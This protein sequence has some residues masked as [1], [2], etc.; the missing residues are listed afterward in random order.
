MFIVKKAFRRAKAVPRLAILAQFRKIRSKIKGRHKRREAPAENRPPVVPSQ[1]AEVFDD[2]SETSL[3]DECVICFRAIKDE[4]LKLKCSHEFHESCL[5][6]W[7]NKQTVCP[8]CHDD[9]EY[10][11]EPV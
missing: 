1:K 3:D 4:G 6:E 9:L 5:R 8:F 10:L 2:E 7:L 11:L